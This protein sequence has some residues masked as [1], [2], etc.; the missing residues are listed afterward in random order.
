MPVRA[1]T[2]VGVSE[3]GWAV[4]ERPLRV[5]VGVVLAVCGASGAA[6]ILWVGWLGP[7]RHLDFF[8]LWS[9]A[10]FLHEGGGGAIYGPAALQAAEQ[11]FSPGFAGFYP[12]P[13]PPSFLAAT[14]W[15]GALPIG[16]AKT[17]WSAGGVAALA[18]AA[19]LMFRRPWPGLAVGAVLAAP[20]TAACL[21]TGETGL[22]T[23]AFLLAGLAWLPGQP[24]L[25]GIAFGLLTLKPQFLVLVPVALLARGAWRAV[26]AA[27]ATAAALVAVS[28]LVLPPALWRGW[29]LSLTDY[30]TLV[31]QNQGRLAHL[32][33]T[34]D[35]GLLCLR[36]PAALA[37]TGQG[38]ASLG[39][40]VI[41]WRAFQG[42]DYRGATAV[43]LAAT[44]LAAPHAFIYDTPELTAALLLFAER[45]ARLSTPL[46]LLIAAIFLLPLGMAGNFAP[47]IIYALPEALLV[48]L[49][50][51]HA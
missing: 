24:V 12:C 1:T 10:R 16:V 6:G 22:F 19:C 26:I 9:F 11:R 33:T 30:Q 41:V 44:P 40:A 28:L 35:A 32:M 3:A 50:V 46:L 38:L 45:R 17:L 29:A 13:Y 31:L 39:L 4:G 47:Y 43:L 20:A 2:K 42:A 8:G 5:A 36:V 7:D 21:V 25:A 34:V 15:L 37:W 48:Y 14:L 51:R 27:G 49:I 23:S 18:G